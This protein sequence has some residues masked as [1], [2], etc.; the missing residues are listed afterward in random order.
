MGKLSE[1][2]NQPK[3]EIK[4][5]GNTIDHPEMLEVGE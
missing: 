2:V 1:Y 4:V 3:V 5:I